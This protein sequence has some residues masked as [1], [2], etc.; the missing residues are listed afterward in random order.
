VSTQLS[1]CIFPVAAQRWLQEHQR[2]IAARTQ[3]D[4]RQYISALLPFFGELHIHEIHVGHLRQYQDW[5]SQKACATRVN[6]EMSTLQQILKEA[7]VWTPI[8]PLY[9]PL[10]V[11]REG[12]GRSLGPDEEARFYAACFKKPR[13]ALAEHCAIVML[14]TGCGFGELRSLR[15]KD[16][17]LKAKVVYIVNGAKNT[18]RVR[19]VPLTSRALQSMGWIVDRYEALGGS[20]P[21]DY[22]LPHRCNKGRGAPD[23]AAPI[24]SIYAAFKGILKDAA[25]EH[26]RLYDCRVTVATKILGSGVP[27]HTSQKLLGHV[28]QAMQRRY[29]KPDLDALRSAVAVLDTA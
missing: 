11:P 27:L 18:Q 14:N 7:N 23:F 5:R 28:S 9:R 25:I 4:Y 13:R 20:S 10:P 12:A 26:F 6:M 29:Y 15:R 8:A 1:Q 19:P 16:V 24:T 22:I 2:Y 21:D 17:D 3:R